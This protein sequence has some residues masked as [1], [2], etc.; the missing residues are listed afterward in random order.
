MKQVCRLYL[1]FLRHIT[2]N[3]TI[4]M[5]RV[6]KMGPEGFLKAYQDYQGQELEPDPSM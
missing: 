4:N 6:M 1:I 2:F 3:E 5:N